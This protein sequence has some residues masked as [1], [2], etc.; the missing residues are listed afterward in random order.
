MTAFHPGD[1][2][3]VMAW[4]DADAGKHGT[5]TKIVSTLNDPMVCVELDDGDRVCFMAGDLRKER[6]P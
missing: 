1:R 3:V 4:G 6:Q 5:V 2:V